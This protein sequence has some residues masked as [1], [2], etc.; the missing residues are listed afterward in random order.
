MEKQDKDNGSE[1]H[2]FPRQPFVELIVINSDGTPVNTFAGENSALPIV[3]K[4]LADLA[5]DNGFQIT[6]CEALL[7]LAQ[8]IYSVDRDLVMSLLGCFYN[9]H[10]SDIKDIGKNLPVTA[11]YFFVVSR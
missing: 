5:P 11:K 10:W 1:F 2:K 7:A 6:R 8:D 3:L 4:R 9:K